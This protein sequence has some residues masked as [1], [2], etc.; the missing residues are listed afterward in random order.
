M[1]FRRDLPPPVVTAE[2]HE[3]GPLRGAIER[4]L[5]IVLSEEG[6]ASW[7]AKQTRVLAAGV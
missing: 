4:A 7:S 1:S 6:L 5:D 3:D 2:Y